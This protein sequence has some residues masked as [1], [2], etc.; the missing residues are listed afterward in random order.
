MDETRSRARNNPNRICH[1]TIESEFRRSINRGHLKNRDDSYPSAEPYICNTQFTLLREI[2]LTRTAK[3]LSLIASICALPALPLHAQSIP[4]AQFT[5]SFPFYVSGRE[6]PAGSYMASRPNMNTD[7]LWIRD[8]DWTHSAFVLY[9]PSETTEPVVHG[10]VTFHHYEDADYLSGL[11]LSG[12]ETGME[13]RESVAE[14][15]AEL[16]EHA[17]ASTKRIALGLTLSAK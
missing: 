6:M 7:V 12:E 15:K 8:A 17:V 5:T 11:T 2:V 16:S 13:I 3:L 9:D 10:E 4:V 14:K 1:F